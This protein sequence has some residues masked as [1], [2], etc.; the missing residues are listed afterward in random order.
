[1]LAVA[2]WSCE[3]LIGSVRREC[4]DH[5]MVLSERYLRHQ[6]AN[7]VTCYNGAHASCARQGCSAPQAGT[8]N[9]AYR[10]NLL[11][12]RSPS[13]ASSGG[14]IGRHRGATGVSAAALKSASSSSLSAMW[15]SAAATSGLFVSAAHEPGFCRPGS[16]LLWH[17]YG[18]QTMATVARPSS[19][20]FATKDRSYGGLAPLVTRPSR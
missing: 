7:D 14:T 4:L 3:R 10:I 15:R 9:R 6:L 19:A 16:D 5:V 20:A 17:C 11:A 12:R 8:N 13:S 18:I 2:E 1:M